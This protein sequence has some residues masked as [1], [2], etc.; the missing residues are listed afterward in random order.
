MKNF[1]IHLLLP[2]HTNNNRAKLLHHSSLLTLILLI[3]GIT[4]IFSSFSKNNS[5]VLGISFSITPQELLVITNQ[6]RQ[7]AGLPALVLDGSLTQAAEKKAADM[8]SK[9]YWAH[10]APDGTTPWFFIRSSGY[11]YLYAGENLARGYT[12]S[13]D[14]INAWMESQSHREN[15]L[16]SNYSDVGFA[17]QEGNLTGEETVLVVEEFGRRVE[18]TPEVANQELVPQAPVQSQPISLGQ[19]PSPVPTRPITPTPTPVVSLTPNISFQVAAYKNDPLINKPA[20]QKNI[21]FIVIVG[22]LML[23]LID[24]IFVQRRGIVRLLSHNLDHIIFFGM[25]LFLILLITKGGVI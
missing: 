11:E 3:F 17:I 25:I 21:A 15:M 20:A 6:K 7:D 9:N 10:I 24:M 12:A 18:N 22:I 19:S 8:L 16:S 14:V 13:N 1:L 5:S 23:L 2:H 4:F